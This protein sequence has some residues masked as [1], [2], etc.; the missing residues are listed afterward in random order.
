MISFKNV[1]YKIKNK[2]IIN[3]I[4]FNIK[5]SEKVLLIGKSGS[6][7]STIINLINKNISPSTGNV[8]FNKKDI[9]S[10]N[11]K[12]INEYRKRHVATIY[13]KDDLF[14]DLSVIDNLELYYYNKDILSLLKKSNLLHLKNR[15]VYSLSGGER[16]RIS[17]IK[18]CLANCDVLL[19]DEITSALDYENAQKIIDFVLKIFND[20]TIIFISHDKSL[21]DNKVDRIIN[22]DNGMIVENIIINEI[23]NTFKNKRVK[24]KPLLNNFVL[25]GLKKISFSSLVIYIILSF[26]F[27][28]T[29]NYNDIFTY[30]AKTSYYNYFDYDV[31][32]VKDNI[33]LTPNNVN[34][35]YNYND[36]FNN[37]K[38]SINNIEKINVMFFP[39]NN[40]DNNYSHLV[41]NSL[42]LE[43]ENIKELS[44]LS[45]DNNYF[46]YKDDIINV[47]NEDNM[48]SIPCIY[49]DIKYFSSL[50]D[51]YKNDELVLIDYDFSKD[52]NR[53]TNNPIFEEKK[54]NKPY[55]DSNAYCDFLTFKMVFSTIKSIVNYFFIMILIF[56]IISNIL[57]NIT[58]IYKD[59]KKIAIYISKGFEDILIIIPY[60]IYP[61]ILFVVSLL[62]CLFNNKLLICFLCSFIIQILSIYISYLYIKKKNIHSI[63]KEDN[64]C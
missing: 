64:L 13:Q 44:Y 2:K 5:K 62:L 31:V 16:Q 55:L 35:F 43:V 49:Y 18:T 23:N 53:F 11:Q 12:E 1:T 7:K 63:L 22:I 42:F 14:D 9:N 45:I 60:V 26:S 54:E 36:L 59:I 17:I 46:K 40:K 38:V 28:I 57:I 41:V 8:Y 21:F 27:F 58:I 34:T 61:I 33:D 19:C 32:I 20:K 29:L 30:Y 50:I 15:F 56:S 3:N 51:E 10:Y 24:N 6:G 48:F 25:N 47:I 4:N 37:S 39:F 52:D